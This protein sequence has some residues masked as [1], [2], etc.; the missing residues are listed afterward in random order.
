[1]SA[2]SYITMKSPIGPLLLAGEEGGLR[3]VHFATG[4]RPK[5]PQRDWIEDRAPFKEVIRQL[6]AYF[7]G[8]LKD[9]DLPLVLDWD[10]IR[11]HTYGIEALAEDLRATT[12]EAIER[13]SGLGR[14][15]IQSAA[16]VYM[17]A[18]SAILV[19]G[20]GI[21]QHKRG[22][23][24]VQQLA[25]LALLRGNIGRPGAGL[26]PVRGHSNVQ[27][28]RTVGITEIPS[29]EFLD[30]L[31]KRF[32]FKPPRDHGH[33][34]VTAL[35]AMLRGEVKVFVALGG[36]FAVAI[37]DWQLTQSALRQLDFTVQ[38]STKLNRSHLVRGREAVILPCLGRTEVDLQASGP[39]SVTVEDSM[40]MVRASAGK[41]RP[42]S[43]Q[44]YLADS[45]FVTS[46]R[47]QTG[48]EWIL[49]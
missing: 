4:R 2:M 15:Q 38:I 26:C 35:E 49:R 44:L 12:W 39:Q 23:E 27:G 47:C 48:D 7:E 14:D 10:F 45:W 13:R 6:V 22:V 3:L 24:N 46:V 42:A 5:S 19:Y 30:R 9:F 28:D 34:V 33:N 41:N 36:N 20:M 43:N 16:Q 25:N 17:Q 40:S 18:Q 37:P 8:K 29:P 31:E 11:G 1:M 32:G 21:T